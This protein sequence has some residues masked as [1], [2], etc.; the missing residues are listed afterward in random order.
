VEYST[1]VIEGPIDNIGL[2]I[3]RSI[4]IVLI[5][6]GVDTPYIHDSGR[7]Y[8][9]IADNTEPQEVKDRNLLDR[10]YSRRERML[11]KR[12]RFLET[13]RIGISNDQ[14]VLNVYLLTNPN[15][16]KDYQ[17]T[18][19]STFTKIFD[20]PIGTGIDKY[21]IPMET[22]HSVP[23]GLIAKHT[24]RNERLTD[25]ISFRW[26]HDGNALIS[27]P[28]NVLEFQYNS[29][30][31]SNYEHYDRFLAICLERGLKDAKAVDLSKLLMALLGLLSSYISLIE[32][33]QKDPEIS[34]S[35]SLFNCGNYLPFINDENFIGDLELRGVPIVEENGLQIPSLD[36]ECRLITLTSPSNTQAKPMER[37]IALAKYIS[38]GI[39]KSVG[40]SSENEP[41]INRYKSLLDFKGVS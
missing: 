31:T 25:H 24:Q 9:R 19:L 41:L 14:P 39:L 37:E 27:I 3:N 12:R 6:E 11:S 40:I 18:S 17:A 5:P 28:I 13:R 4:I 15:F 8:L 7:I 20:S 1:K 32:E 16:D 26:W 38:E 33:T 21:H 36:E 2:P 10:L 34:L 30:I 35:F 29:T 23:E 22:I